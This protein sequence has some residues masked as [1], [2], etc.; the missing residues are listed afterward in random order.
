[1][2]KAPHA[3]EFNENAVSRI[4]RILLVRHGY[5]MGN[6]DHSQYAKL[7]DPLIPLHDDGWKQAIKAGE[8]LAQHYQDHP[9]LYENGPSVWASSY[10]R[11]RETLGGIVHG[12]KGALDHC[13]PI[14]ESPDM[15]E[16]D[17]GMKSFLPSEEMKKYRAIEDEFTRTRLEQFKFYSRLPHGES[18]FD[19]YLRMGDVVASMQRDCQRK[20]Q[21]DFLVVSHGVS[22]R[23]FAMRFLHIPDRAWEHF[24][25]PGNCDIMA[26]ELQKNGRYSLKKIYDG[27]SGLACDVDLL[28]D[29]Q[30]KV[31]ALTAQT[32][33]KP[34]KHLRR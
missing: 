12:A 5:S 32:L 4:Q 26:I 29:L 10:L 15:V 19:T 21:N 1:M 22:A 33:P 20:G 9:P 14:H 28:S 6:H 16:Q 13:H 3:P 30:A 18:P 31:P 2:T 7:G 23:T 17:F 11:T 34:P 8:F 24:K 27:P 25:N